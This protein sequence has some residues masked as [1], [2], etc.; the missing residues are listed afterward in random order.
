MKNK[1]IKSNSP[2]IYMRNKCYVG[3]KKF[4]NLNWFHKNIVLCVSHIWAE[5]E[6]MRKSKSKSKSSL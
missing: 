5:V 1:K 2:T 3:G 6:S 4:D